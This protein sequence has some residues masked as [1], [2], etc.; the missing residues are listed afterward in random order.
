[1]KTLFFFLLLSLF[2]VNAQVKVIWDYPVKPGSEE[3]KHFDSVDAMY[4]ACQIPDQ[5]LKKLDTQSL[6]EI[7]YNYPAFMSLFVYNSPQDG[8]DAFYSNFNGIRELVNRKDVGVNM[9]KK[10]QSISCNDFNPLWRSEIK[11]GFSFKIKYFE[12]ILAQDK[13]LLT[14]DVTNQ[15]LLMNE[16]L[17]KFEEKISNNDLFGGSSITVNAW[18]LA[19]ILS[20]ENKLSIQGGSL[21]IKPEINTSLNTGLLSASDVQSVYQQVKIISHE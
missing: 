5:I 18:I 20:I 8:F 6:L 11:G 17:L 10:Y 2:S 12:T 1:M 19:K 3:W 14:L 13:V 9:L 4:E 7:C 21:T 16:A 15:K